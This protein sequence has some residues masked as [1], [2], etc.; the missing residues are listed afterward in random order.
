MG[1]E[2]TLQ[3]SEES[4]GAQ[5]TGPVEAAAAEEKRDIAAELKEEAHAQSNS[6]KLTDE[7]IA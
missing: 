5:S 4:L 2:I 7:S 6:E 3:D 1:A